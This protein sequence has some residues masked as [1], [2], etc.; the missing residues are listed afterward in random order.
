MRSIESEW[1]LWSERILFFSTRKWLFCKRT[2]SR[3]WSYLW[4]MDIRFKAPALALVSCSK[5]SVALR[6]DTTPYGIYSR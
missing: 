2:H 6:E 5:F 1:E 4:T 3:V